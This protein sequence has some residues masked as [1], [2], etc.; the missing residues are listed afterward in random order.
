MGAQPDWTG[1]GKEADTRDF[2]PA[3]TE[4][5][6]HEDTAKSPSASEEKRLR[7]K[8]TLLAPWTLSFHS[9]CGAL[10]W[11]PEL[12]NPVPLSFIDGIFEPSSN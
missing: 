3:C 9:V 1:K 7:Q 10:L 8:P 2:L 11:P 12:T 4:E 6:P 5:R